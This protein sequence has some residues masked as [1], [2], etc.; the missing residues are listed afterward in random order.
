VSEPVCFAHED[1]GPDDRCAFCNVKRVPYLKAE[2][3]SLSKYSIHLQTELG[4]SIEYQGKL[5]AQLAQA[6]ARIERLALVADAAVQLYNALAAQS[7]AHFEHMKAEWPE[8]RHLKA[9]FD[10]LKKET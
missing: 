7:G 8:L 5:K 1:T 10:N 4:D 6:Q 9:S 3:E 2:M